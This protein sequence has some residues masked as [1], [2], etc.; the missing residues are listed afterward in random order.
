MASEASHKK[1]TIRQLDTVFLYNGISWLTNS[2]CIFSCSTQYSNSSTNIDDT[3]RKFNSSVRAEIQQDIHFS[4]CVYC[5]ASI[6]IGYLDL[7]IYYGTTIIKWWF[8][9]DSNTRE[10]S[11]DLVEN[12]WSRNICVKNKL[13]KQEI[14]TE[15]FSSPVSL[16]MTDNGEEN[17][18]VPA[19]FCAAI[20][21][22]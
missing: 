12:Y 11:G 19:S 22:M 2:I 20:F 3:H 7:I 15:N 6:M 14:Y 8:P 13:N 1:L 18:P 16:V 17:S 5:S 4:V 10:V 9:R 21:S